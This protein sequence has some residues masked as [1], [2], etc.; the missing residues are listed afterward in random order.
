MTIWVFFVSDDAF[1]RR[2]HMTK[3]C[4]LRGLTDKERI[5]NYRLSRA[6]TVAKNAFGILANRFLILLTTTQHHSSTVKIIVK[7]CIILHNL[8]RMRYPT[9]KSQQLDRAENV[10]RDFIPGAWRQGWNPQGIHVVSGKHLQQGWKEA[11]EPDQTLGQ[12]RSQ[13]CVMARQ[14]LVE[15]MWLMPHWLY[16]LLS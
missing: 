15:E 10:N 2:K 6:R 4:T 1:G 3:P 16:K 13:F 11:A 12:P 8:M 9:L 7:A 5:F 14:D